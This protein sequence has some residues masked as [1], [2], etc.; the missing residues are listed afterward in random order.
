[1]N[2]DDLIRLRHM[3][4]A[5]REALGFARGRTRADLDSDRMLLRALTKTI[6]IVGEAAA[7]VSPEARSGTPAIPWPGIVTMRNRLVHGYFD[8]NKDIVWSTVTA[9][10]PTLLEE[11]D[12]ILP[13][14]P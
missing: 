2:N 14:A 11:L 10:L 5:A 7:S 4:D 6:E 8:I 9:D 3:A 13:S 1:M 12:K